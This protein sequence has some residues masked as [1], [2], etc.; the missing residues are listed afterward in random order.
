MSA[1]GWSVREVR[2][3]LVC[4]RCG[5]QASGCVLTPEEA[6]ALECRAC[7]GCEWFHLEDERPA[8]EAEAGGP[9]R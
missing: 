9:Y 2:G 7:G 5:E 4:A 8:I 1:S 3:L 6:R